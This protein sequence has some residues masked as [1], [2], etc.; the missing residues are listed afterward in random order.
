MIHSRNPLSCLSP[1]VTPALLAM[2]GLALPACDPDEPDADDGADTGGSEGGTETG[3]PSGECT[4]V[5]QTDLDADLTLDAGCYEVGT[6]L[7]VSSSTLTLLPGVDLRFAAGAGLQIAA[8]G[9][10]VA[11]GDGEAPVMMSADDPDAGAWAGLHFF[12]AASS[13]NVLGHVE[14]HD[15]GAGTPGAA[16]ALTAG[17]RVRIEAS[18]IADNP[19]LGILVD[20]ASTLELAASTVTA[21]DAPL[22]VGIESVAGIAAD[23]LLDGND[24]DIAYVTGTTLTTDATW[25]AIGVPLHPEAD[26]VLQAH[27]TLAAGTVLAMDQERSI[28][29][30]TQGALTTVGTQDAPVRITGQTQEV[31]FWKGISFESQTNENFLEGASIEFAGSTQWNGDEDS[32]AALWLPEDGK[33]ILRDSAVTG[34]GWYGLWTYGGA[35]IEGLSGNRFENNARIMVVHPNLVGGIAGDNAFVDNGEQLIRVSFGNN[36][37]IESAQTWVDPG[38]PYHLNVRTWVEAPLVLEAGVT[39]QF[40]Q[41]SSL[42][43]D[44]GGSLHADGTADAPVHMVGAEALPGYWVGLQFATMAADNRLGHTRIEHAGGE[45][46]HGGDDSEAAIYV[47]GFEGEGRVE[48]EEVVIAQ[49]AGNGI[50]VADDGSTL[51]CSGVTYEAIAKG[52]VSGPA[53][54]DCI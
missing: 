30:T 25:P 22:R 27:L 52:T 32:R 26:V 9:V 44:E 45:Q 29:V 10:L 15:A 48:L 53:P 2:A 42:R 23:N 7:S 49:S 38:V 33:V 35:E 40:D 4:P 19:A 50:L 12:G 20:Q 18:T 36:D 31:G 39:L 17:A 16:V 34:S 47:G 51:S 14:L 5:E 11:A 21:N 6:L 43:I 46:W 28:T 54:A 41:E 37:R 3:E 8:G 13:N 1:L 24:E